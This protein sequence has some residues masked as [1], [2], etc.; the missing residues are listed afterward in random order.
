[1]EAT[2]SFSEMVAS[3]PGAKVHPQ[4]PTGAGDRTLTHAPAKLG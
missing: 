1:M 2:R 3:M 4:R